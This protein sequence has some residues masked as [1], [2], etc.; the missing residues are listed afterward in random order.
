MMVAQEKKRA[1][2]KAAREAK[3]QAIMD[4][5]GDVIPKSDDAEKAFDKMILKQSL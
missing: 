5:M 1:E 4:K 3:V 2:V